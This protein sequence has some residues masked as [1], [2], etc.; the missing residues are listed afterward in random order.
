[1]E[2]VIFTIVLSVLFLFIIDSAFPS[3]SVV[4]PAEPLLQQLHKDIS[5]DGIWS[6]VRT[7]RSD[8]DALGKDIKLILKQLGPVKPEPAETV[9]KAI[10]LLSTA[11]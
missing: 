2:F 1:M 9:K 4:G 8:V 6:E 3:S 7:L 11:F 10:D 5:T